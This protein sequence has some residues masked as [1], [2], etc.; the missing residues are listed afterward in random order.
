M[1]KG[2][3][4]SIQAQEGVAELHRALDGYL[5][6]YMNKRRQIKPDGH[7]LPMAV[8]YGLKTKGF[9]LIITITK[10]NFK[11][12]FLT[13]NTMIYIIRGCQIQKKKFCDVW[14]NIKM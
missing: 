6:D 1:I 3:F 2:V 13:L 5:S 11:M 4:A 14:L 9:Y 12:S 8:F 10:N 7:S